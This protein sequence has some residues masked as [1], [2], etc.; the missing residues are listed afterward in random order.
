MKKYLILLC[1]AMTF[2][3]CSAQQKISLPEIPPPP[4]ITVS[5]LGEGESAIRLSEVKVDVKVIGPM[6]VTTLD[7]IF[8][9]PNSRIL[10]GDFQFPL[11]EG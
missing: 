11:A 4:A 5:K 6:A 9:N 2:L 8:Y 3:A 1:S 10:E 7:M